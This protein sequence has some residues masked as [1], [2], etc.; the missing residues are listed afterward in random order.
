MRPLLRLIVVLG[1]LAA[2]SGLTGVGLN[3]IRPLQLNKGKATKYMFFIQP[4]T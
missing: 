3:P 2:V 4:E 1:L